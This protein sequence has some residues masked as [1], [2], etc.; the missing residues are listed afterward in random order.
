MA[1]DLMTQD[2]DTM[3][4]QLN[5]LSAATRSFNGKLAQMARVELPGMRYSA[6]EIPEMPVNKSP[7]SKRN[8]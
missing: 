4:K 8:V 5:L 1:L 7:A 3:C 6:D 2:G